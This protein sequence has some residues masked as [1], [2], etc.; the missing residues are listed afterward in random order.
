[1]LGR[2]TRVYVF[3]D[4]ERVIAGPLAKCCSD[5]Q[6]RR[7]PPDRLMEDSG[8]ACSQTTNKL[9]KRA[10]ESFRIF[11]RDNRG[12]GT[13]CYCRPIE[14]F[15]FRIV[16]ALR[17]GPIDLIEDLFALFFVEFDYGAQKLFSFHLHIPKIRPNS[18]GSPLLHSFE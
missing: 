17:N 3:C 13:E 11:F 9:M 5:R 7:D 12:L 14:P 4:P 18:M 15:E 6:P 16:I 2:T 10:F 1:M 8:V